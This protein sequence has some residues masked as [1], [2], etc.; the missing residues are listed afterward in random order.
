MIYKN[1]S[2]QSLSKNVDLLYYYNNNINNNNNNN[3]N[4][5]IISDLYSVFTSTEL[6]VE[7]LILGRPLQGLTNILYTN[8]LYNKK[9]C[10]TET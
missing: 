9:Y 3:N 10:K 8:D 2:V 7:R 5:I 6:T 4:I 1:L